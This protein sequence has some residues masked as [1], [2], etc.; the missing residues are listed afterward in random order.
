[1]SDAKPPAPRRPNVIPMLRRI[2]DVV[3]T[4]LGL[5]E[6]VDQL[7]AKNDVLT[8]KVDQLRLEVAQQAGQLEVLLK[9]IS[10]ALNA[11]VDKRAEAAAR[12]I[13]AEFEAKQRSK[14][15]PRKS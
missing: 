14:S 11:Q 15:P 10:G 6:S 1:M 7:K 9:F 5:V 13:I 8:T 2:G 12:A 3:R 4:V